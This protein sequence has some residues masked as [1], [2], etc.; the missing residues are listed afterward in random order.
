[1]SASFTLLHLITWTLHQLTSPQEEGWVQCTRYF[2]KRNQISITS[3]ILLCYNVLLAINLL[4]CLIYKL[5]FYHRL[6]YVKIHNRCVGGWYLPWFQA[7]TGVLNSR[8]VR[9]GRTTGGPGWCMILDFYPCSDPAC[10]LA[11]VSHSSERPSVVKLIS[12][13]VGR[14]FWR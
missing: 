5:T 10:A 9:G 2:G 6:I 12:A 11:G 1:M 13:R 7:S 8:W 3:I 14:S 4:M